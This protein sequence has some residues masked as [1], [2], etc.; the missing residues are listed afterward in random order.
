MDGWLSFSSGVPDSAIISPV[1]TA[2]LLICNL[3]AVPD[4]G[5]LI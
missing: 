3:S 5:L 1:K 2:T 4:M